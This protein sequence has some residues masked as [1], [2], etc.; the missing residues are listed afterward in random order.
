MNYLD[1]LQKINNI[2]Y[3]I[4]GDKKFV[5]NFQ[6][7]I[8]QKRFKLNKTDATEIIIEDDDGKFVQ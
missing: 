1:I 5:I 7:Y 3:N 2:L 4:F 6:V 8:N